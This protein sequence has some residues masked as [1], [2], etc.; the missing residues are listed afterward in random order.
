[1]NQKALPVTNNVVA[2]PAVRRKVAKSL[3][4]FMLCY[5]PHYLT[6]EPA[7]FHR[8]LIETLQNPEKKFIAREGFRGSAK[9]SI[10]A[11]AFVLWS[12]L[13]EKEK[14]IIPVNETDDVAKL[15]IAN[16][17]EEL[18]HNP[19]IKADYG[20]QIVNK[21]NMTKF[22]ETNIL[23]ANG[24]RIM[25]RSRGQKIRGLRHKQFRPGL[26][27]CDDI[28]EVE[29]VDKKTYRDKTE[30]WLTGTVIPAIEEFEGRLIVLG[31]KLHTDAIM[32]RLKNH[33]IFDYKEYP[34][35]D[36]DGKCTWPAKYPT[37]ESLKE[38]EMKV[39]RT[40]WMRE[41]LLKVVPTEGQVVT[42]EMIHYY[43]ELPNQINVAGTGVDLAISQKATAD[44]TTMV[45]GVG[46]YID[47]KPN[48]YILPKPVNE[49]LTFNET[50]ERMKLVRQ[51]LNVY[52]AGG[53]F[54]I[55]DVAYQKAAIQEAQRNMLA[56]VPMKAVADKR[57]RFKTAAIYIENGTVK[58][59]RKGC[60]ELINQMLG[61]GIEEHDDLVDGLV[62]LILGLANTGLQKLEVIAL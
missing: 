18:E 19:Y 15:T 54:Y 26:V 17:R 16:I 41:Y 14:F 40:S 30:R 60:E 38:Q 45:S 27:I 28:E 35:I 33:P 5:L 9:S 44:Y 52:G 8:E 22:S 3:L 2:H 13:E 39:G 34:L 42:E 25:A 48:V 58:F 57:A 53:T 6:L 12:A 29:K 24:C 56:V 59:P 4:G 47:G 36:K 31:N 46:T 49:R 1:M 62:H 51:G 50:I 7:I 55:E 61:F 37:Q 20:D 43:D 21:K 23:L 11:L 10:A 32:E